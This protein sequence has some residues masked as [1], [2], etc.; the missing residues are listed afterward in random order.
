MQ[1][2]TNLDLTDLK[3]FS[4][5]KVRN[6]YDLGDR[7]LIV[8]SDRI[9]A[10]DHVL[11]T[12][13]PDKGKI[14]TALSAFWFRALEPVARHH[15]ISTDI[16]DF[17][18]AAARYGDLVRGRSMLVRRAE[19]V[20]IECIVR[21]YLA[22]S[23]WKEYKLTGKVAGRELPPGLELNSRLER[24]IFTPSTKAEDG[25]DR[26]I[27][28]DEMM[29]VVGAR[30]G[31]EVVERSLAVFEAARHLAQAKGITIVDTKLEFGRID[32]EL[33]LIDEVFTPDSSRFLAALE[34]AGAGAA[35]AGG[36]TAVPGDG[37]GRVLNLD[38][39]FVRDY[40]DRTGWDKNPPAPELPPQIVNE[41]RRR[42]LLVLERLTGERP[43]WAR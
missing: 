1:A 29:D 6:V 37:V 35:A 40:L 43:E 36:A 20:D 33:A 14:L 25:H 18:P 41:A 5:G 22:G 42:Y 27:T 26:N 17:P 32:G 16:C 3:L 13:I 4:K 39:Q 34:G 23:A 11:A 7:L 9:S 21:G 28:L 2:L 15:M 30:V 19:R 10:Y 31:E 24:A 8:A 12:G 38:K